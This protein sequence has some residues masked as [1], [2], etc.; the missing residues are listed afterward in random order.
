MNKTNPE[1]SAELWK[2]YFNAIEMFEQT[3]HKHANASKIEFNRSIKTD[4]VAISFV[5]NRQRNYSANKGGVKPKK[6]T[7]A[8]QKNELKKK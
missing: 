5:M 7:E 2:Y 3:P 1:Q 8:A 6:P 4:G